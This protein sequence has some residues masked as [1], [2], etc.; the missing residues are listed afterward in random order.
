[1]KS[2]LVLC[3]WLFAL[4]TVHFGETWQQLRVNGIDPQNLLKTL[5]LLELDGIDL[6]FEGKNCATLVVNEEQCARLMLSALPYE[7][8]I[9][10]LTRYYAERCQNGLFKASP[11][12]DSLG[13]GLPFGS[14]GGYYTMTE[15]EAI[16]DSFH[17]NFPH[18]V[19][20]K[21]SIGQSIEGRPIYAF[22]VS[23]FPDQDDDSLRTLITSLIH[24]REAQGMMSMIY[25]I[26]YLIQSYENDPL[27]RYLVNNREILFI[28]VVNPD[29][30]QQNI[31]TNPYGGGMWRKN[32]RAENL[33]VYG[34]DLNRNFAY[35]WGYDNNGSS[36]NRNWDTYRGASPFSEPESQAI[37]EL[38]IQYPFQTALNY[39]TYSNLLIFPWSY[40]DQPSP[41]DSIYQAIGSLMTRDNHYLSGTS[42]QTVQYVVNGGTDDW[43]YGEQTE[44]PK[45]FAFTME[46]GNSRDGF[47]PQAERILP[48]A[49]RCLIANIQLVKLTG[50]SPQILS[51][52]IQNQYNWYAPGD[53]L[54]FSLHIKN[55]GLKSMDESARII[56][57]QAASPDQTIDI[58]MLNSQ[59]SVEITDIPV[60]LPFLTT[61]ELCALS[62]HLSYENAIFDSLILVRPVGFPQPILS[63]NFDQPGLWNFSQWELD[64]TQYYTAPGCLSDSPGRNY[65]PSQLRSTYSPYFVVPDSLETWLTFKTKWDIEKYYDRGLIE[66]EDSTSQFASSIRCGF[67]SPGSGQNSFQDENLFGYDG[68]QDNWQTEWVSLTDFR[69]KKIRL[70]FCLATDNSSQANGW[71]LDDILVLHYPQPSEI[72]INESESDGIPVLCYPNP[73]HSHLTIQRKARTRATLEFFDLLGRQLTRFVTL[74]HSLEIDLSKICSAPGVLFLRISTE[75]GKQTIHRLVYLP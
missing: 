6:R 67:M 69:G 18:I 4:A 8:V 3:A 31:T 37:R 52:T 1:M 5:K 33:Q 44:K 57:K 73:A 46:L 22:K 25:F 59:Q 68:T 55:C 53:T 20:E 48:I 39:H 42:A 28:P 61:P 58:P 15:I 35:C 62:F 36:G 9:S 38:C 16:I 32:R 56:L 13:I 74:E 72:D 10:D 26:R 66:I 64:S 65:A 51:Y 34:V 60:I 70:K 11:V 24:A 30:Y 40:I 45:T 12:D 50:A 29:G 71:S 2:I 47:W 63:E 14:M 7:I 27:I 21:Y 23:D 75:N 17:F 49:Q 19:G 54:H 41:D 43:M